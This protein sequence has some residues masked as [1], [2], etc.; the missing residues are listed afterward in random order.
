MT[1]NIPGED[2]LNRRQK[3]VAGLVIRALVCAT[4]ILVFALTA[5]LL[6]A[7]SRVHFWPA[8]A[9]LFL[10]FLVNYPFWLAGKAFGFPLGHFYA[11]W[12]IDLLLVT[13]I[14]HVL[15]G[16]ELPCG[17][18]G[19]MIMILTSAVFL[20]QKASFIVAA[21]STICFD[22]LILLEAN[23]V[24]THQ[25]DIWAHSYTDAAQ[26]I[27]VLASN[28]FFFLFASMAG[29]LAEE[30]RKANA[31]LAAAQADLRQYNQTLED[32]VAERTL[33]LQEKNREI[34]EFVHIVTHDLR[35][36]SVGVAE[37]ARRLLN[38]EK[39]NLSSRGLRY[40][41]NLLDDTR[42]MNGMLSHLLALF[43]VDHEREDPS[44]A[45]VKALVES[46]VS[47]AGNR[48][49]DQ[50]V[51]FELGS[52]PQMRVDQLQLRHVLSNLLDNAVKYSGDK[53]QPVI[54]VDCVERAECYQIEVR[55]NGIGIAKDQINRI[56]QLYHRAP[57]QTVAGIV[58]TGH[59]VGLAISKR[60]VERWGG[61][62]WVESK[63]GRGTS[64]FFTCPKSERKRG[65]GRER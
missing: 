45:D 42:N 30:L 33:A 14:V 9:L 56:F 18:V 24:I 2:V 50:R 25:E 5:S 8:S 53:L 63:E 51:L 54:R 40:A 39:Q 35:N 6:P 10:L 3:Y 12:A 34:E 55:D 38:T 27:I 21:G 29:A 61:E 36:V 23:G 16:V 48:T 32:H 58:Q 13:I 28:V 47:A 1:S 64:F 59:G 65:A 49:N 26:V 57:N 60:I 44:D 37:L 7:G 43:R 62:I 20:S 52:L 15:G 19:Y 31:A 22:G 17:F 46:L 4:F 11:H 41:S